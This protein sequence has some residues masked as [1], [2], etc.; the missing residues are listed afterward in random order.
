MVWASRPSPEH[1]NTSQAVGGLSLLIR[2]FFLARVIGRLAVNA[3]GGALRQCVRDHSGFVTHP[4]T[5]AL[6]FLGHTRTQTHTHTHTHILTHVRRARAPT[7]HAYVPSSLHISPH[8]LSISFHRYYTFAVS[9]AHTRVP[10]HA[11]SP[12]TH[13]ASSLVNACTRAHAEPTFLPAYLIPS[14]PR[15]LHH[16]VYTCAQGPGQYAPETKPAVLSR[17]RS[18]HQPRFAGALTTVD[19]SKT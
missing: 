17:D 12:L 11:R 9:L 15:R 5:R 3:Y 16:F 13:I 18:P 2:T 6:A 14:L 7:H 1:Y 10:K 19:R 4:R 8:H